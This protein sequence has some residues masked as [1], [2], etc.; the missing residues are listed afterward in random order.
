MTKIQV[1]ENILEVRGER[2]PDDCHEVT[3]RRF[4]PIVEPTVPSNA[5]E[6]YWEINLDK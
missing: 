1:V 5:T 2:V 3:G 4:F 6:S